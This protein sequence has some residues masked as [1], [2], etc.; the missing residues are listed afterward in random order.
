MQCLQTD[1]TY[2]IY[3]ILSSVIYGS[4]RKGG[5]YSFWGRID[6]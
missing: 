6:E 3:V 2:E 5:D 1:G 4:L